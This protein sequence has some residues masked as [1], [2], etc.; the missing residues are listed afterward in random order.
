LVITCTDNPVGPG[1]PGLG[2]LRVAPTFDAFARNAPLTLDN[3]RVIVVRP[4][5][6]TV[7]RVSRSFSVSSSQLTLNIPLQL[8]AASEDLEVTLELYAGTTLLFSGT[9]IVRVAQ[10]L[11]PAPDSVPVAYQGPGATIAAITI[12]P[13]DTTVVFGGSFLFGATAVD[14]QQ[15]PVASF[16]V[17]WTASA[18]TIDAAG[19]FTAPAARDTVTVTATTPSGITD[20]TTVIV[21]AAPATLVKVSGDNQ[22]GII[23][24]VL[25]QPLVVRV[26]G[27]DGLPVAGVPVSFAATTGGGSVDSAT[28]VSNGAGLAT[29]GATLGAT[30]GAQS[31]T[32]TAPGLTAVV[33]AATGTGG[34]VKT[35]AGTLSSDWNT[36]GNW[37]PAAVPVTTDS[38]AIPAGTPNGPLLAGNATIRTLVLQG[39]GSGLDVTGNLTVSGLVSLPDTNSFIDIPNG[40]FA[41][42]SVS[43]GGFQAFIDVSGGVATVGGTLSLTGNRSFFEG[44]P[45][46]A[47][48]PVIL[49]GTQAF[50]SHYGGTQGP[51]TASGT[52]AFWEAG[53]AVTITGSPAVQLTGTAFVSSFGGPAVVTINGD[54]TVGGSG[55]FFDV[56]GGDHFTINGNLTTTGGGYLQ[57]TQATDT[58][59]VN[60]NI[61]FGGGDE[62]GRLIAGM[63]FVSGN[64]SQTGGATSF[65]GSGSHTVF[66]DG[67]GAQTLNFASPG[68]AASRFHNVIIANSAGGVT[69]TSDLYATGT[70]G[71]TPTAVRTLSGNGSTLFTTILNVSNFTFSNL[72]L[73]FAG[74]TVVTF[75][76]VTFQG[77]APTATPLTIAHP[78]AA[79]PLPFLDVSFSVVPTSGF[80]ISATDTNPTDGVPLVIDMVSPSPADPAGRVQTAGG[81]TVNWSGAAPVITWTG[82]V[83]TAW[84]VAGN[85]STNAVPASGD[86]VVII[87]A[88]NQPVLTAPV[89]V[90]AVDIQGGTLTLNGSPMTVGRSF[91]T[92]GTGTVTM[93]NPADDLFIGGDAIFAGGNELGLMSTGLTRIGGSL[94]QLA[95]NSPDSYHPSGNHTTEFLGTAFGISFAT[96]NIIPGSSH[97]QNLVLPTSATIALGSDAYTHGSVGLN[98]TGPLTITGSNRLFQTGS[99]GLGSG[100]TIFDGVR[101]IIDA[102]GTGASSLVQN[103]VFSN[104]SQ[105]VAQLTVIHPDGQFTF[106]SVGFGNV[107][108]T[109]FYLVATDANPSDGIPLT[110]TMTS[111]NPA[112]PGTFIQA[113]NGAVINWSAS[114]LRTWTGASSTDWGTAGNWSPAQVPI[115]TSD[116]VIPAGTPNDPT[117]TSSVTVANLTVQTGAVLSLGDIQLTVTGALD[118]SGSV[119]GCCSDL[120]DVRGTVRGNFTD[121]VLQ[122]PAGQVVTLSGA[123]TLATSTVQLFGELILGGNTLNAGQ[124]SVFIGNGTGLLT[125]TNPADVL[126]AGSV[127]FS[128]GD[129][130]G[131]LTAG[132]IQTQSLFQ[133]SAGGQHPASFFAG[134]NHRVVL[135]GPSSSAVSFANPATSRFQ[136][137]DLS[138][139]SAALTL[140]SNVTVAG[141]LVAV[142]PT[143]SGPVVNGAGFTL[144]AGGADIGATGGNTALTF[145][146]VPLV[147]SGGAITG[148]SHVTF[149]NQ[150]PNGTALTVNNVGTPA[151]FIFSNLTFTTALSA[152][153]F[154]LVANDLDGLSPDSLTINV[155][156]SSPAS[157]TGV[158]QA[159]NGA[160]INWPPTG[161]L[162]TWTG[163][164]SQD[165]FTPGNWDLGS[166][167]GAIDNV[168]FPFGT[169]DPILSANAAVNDLFM[170]SGN[171][172][173]DVNTLVVGG[174]L[175]VGG[176]IQ[177]LPGSGLVLTCSGGQQIGATAINVTTAV[178]GNC[179]LF[180]ATQF[181]DLA[182]QGSLDVG[183]VGLS[184]IGNLTTLGN[185]VLIMTG[186]GQVQ[187]T[188]DAIF[189]GGSTAGLLTA[190]ILRIGGDFIQLATTSP[191]SFAADPGHLTELSAN[192]ASITFTTPGING[193]HF[194]DL[195]E[196]GFGAQFILN[197]DVDV[198]GFLS[199]ADGFGGS[200]L[201]GSCPVTLTVTRWD[202]SVTLDCVRLVLDDPAGTSTGMNDVTFVNLPTDVTQ[203]TIRHPGAAAG[204]FSAGTLNFVPLTGGDPGLYIDATDLDASP[205]FL[206][207][208][209]FNSNVLNGASFTATAGGA[210][211]FWQNGTVTWTGAVDN[212]WFQPG[213]WDQLN[214]PGSADSVVVP[215]TAN[216]P[217]LT[218]NVF[219]GALNITGGTL[220]VNGNT[221]N[222]ARNF[223]TTGT[224]TVTM[225]SVFSLML[226]SGD[227]LFAGGSTNGLL[228]AGEIVVSGSFTQAA[229]TSVTSYAPS[230][231]HRTTVGSANPGTISF[232]SPGAG[233]AGS[234]FHVLDLSNATGG[235]TLTVNSIADSVTASNP[236]A[237][238]AGGGSSLTMRRA[239]IS[240]LTVDNAPLILDEQGAFS[241]ENLS[242]ITFQ[243]FGPTGAQVLTISGPGGTLAARPPITTTSVNFNP[244][245]VGAGNLYVKVTSTNGGFITLTMTG[246]NQSP[247][248]GGNGPALSDPPNQTTVGGVTI[249][250]P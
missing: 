246:S 9:R 109:G 190:G 55:A 82:A 28:V 141:Q 78:G 80:Y 235:V 247:Q 31:F 76:T 123:T 34:A 12:G 17:G 197:S 222:V 139:V 171:L 49:S 211:V 163:A 108:T 241:A 181:A 170:A 43:L 180:T 207:V 97:F 151:A 164:V 75:D 167:P 40:Q 176:F 22:S 230:G 155:L 130:T 143:G 131:R 67:A 232:A 37:S 165:W 124:G 225:T 208:D 220:T 148:V 58:V 185:G 26:D 115:S 29:M 111:P 145:D 120:V 239:Q 201:G 35:W 231:S 93:T 221:V 5:S 234:H 125:M 60:G 39:S 83:S 140:G 52:A 62:S 105:T 238:L 169:P 110:I 182:I 53:G 33:F 89:S 203:L 71:V 122:V 46:S 50:V 63:L 116:V 160:V 183:S 121:V 223:A 202:N 88:T 11:T 144:T 218:G 104:Q 157:G 217:S 177:G 174:D 65:V 47:I 21:A 162:F 7:A 8:Q 79:A 136:E 205:P 57:M 6:D 4:P 25:P 142:L 18:G 1:R 250:W 10:G 87:A 72:L 200:F 199:G 154:H 213:N 95:S 138:G 14:S 94:S 236:S 85:W 249:N 134:G 137:L 2:S 81:A 118:A 48:G 196:S 188:G 216:Q 248:V 132:T 106:P 191:S 227:A 214:V 19:Q 178:T 42:G 228:T 161:S 91:R 107:P 127:D 152:G 219:V 99:L 194:G 166:V 226:I 66:L 153:G 168:T 54:V 175:N 242:N 23:G 215:L 15:A 84:N 237:V 243:G 103:V 146:G 233:A 210:S 101:V 204:N 156:A 74:S 92:G 24:S 119:T 240:G 245:G 193:S 192:P 128:G 184:V 56:S 224:G 64:F 45:G 189:G 61:S 113:N 96:P 229:G 187:V 179:I 150:N 59:E 102:T 133:G 38:V 195:A 73:N 149:Q 159:N 32:A 114:P 41:A 206:V 68:F 209:I 186:P 98:G 173:L 44:G 70:A 129:E 77:Y 117:L 158:S 147:L 112:D 90:G 198:R 86:S 69:A 36:A 244:L 172:I 16:Y 13:R 51:V 20:Q 126:T 30:V 27:T 212:N 3:V 100:T 135:G